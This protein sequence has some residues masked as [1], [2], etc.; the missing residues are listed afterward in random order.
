MEKK[1]PHSFRRVF[2]IAAQVIAFCGLS[3]IARADETAPASGSVSPATGGM[4]QQGIPFNGALA[5]R[6]MVKTI[7]PEAAMDMMFSSIDPVCQKALLSKATQA[8]KAPPANIE[9]MRDNRYFRP[10]IAIN[11][12]FQQWTKALPG[13]RQQGPVFNWMDPKNYWGWLRLN[14]PPVE[15][16][17]DKTT[18]SS[19]TPPQRY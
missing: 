17:A 19:L 7:G 5:I 16:G 13:G 4:P 12:Q 9:E 3:S 11:T 1:P 8:S 6:N 10:A 14:P 15:A 2:F 18:P